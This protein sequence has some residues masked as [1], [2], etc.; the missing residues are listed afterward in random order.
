MGTKSPEVAARLSDKGCSHKGV[1]GRA[2]EGIRHSS[3]DG[4]PSLG[5]GG[6]TPSTELGAEGSTAW[7][8]GNIWSRGEPCA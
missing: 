2:S 6:S 7:K 8:G 3:P 5:H 4:V 1:I